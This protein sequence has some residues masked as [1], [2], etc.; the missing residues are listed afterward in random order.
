MSI[1]N[2][3]GTL[4]P[5]RRPR[6]AAT[7]SDFVIIMAQGRSGSTL[8]LRMLNAVPGVR[9]A[10][11]NQKA[12]DHLRSFVDCFQTADNWTRDCKFCSQA[13]KMPRPLDDVKRRTA[14]FLLDLYNPGRRCRLAGFKEIRYG[15]DYDELVRDVAFL[16]DLFP[17]LRI[18]FNTRL[19]DNAVKSSFWG[20]NPDESRR[21][22]DASRENFHRFHR[23]NPGFTYVMPYEDLR[24]NSPPLRGMFDF[25]NVDFTPA[26]RA[27]LNVKL[28]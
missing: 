19:T 21:I 9:I 12:L 11:E 28:R 27:E 18:V 2:Y 13:W 25:L 20:D 14:D 24:D 3:C 7:S 6:P 22:L 15:R 10:G 16:R 5:L 8:L 23:A 17:S 4:L 1:L 26:A